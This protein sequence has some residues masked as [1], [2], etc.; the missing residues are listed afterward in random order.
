MSAQVAERLWSAE[1]FLDWERTQPYKHE[2]IDNRVY[3]MTGAS[4]AHN[5]IGVKLAGA[6]DRRLTDR[7]CEVYANDMRV[8]VT[9]ESTYTYPDVVVV[10]GEPR[11]RSGIKPDTLENPTLI[12][13]ILSPTTELIDRNRKLDQYLEMKSVRS[14]FLVSQDKPRI[15]SYSRQDDG[16]LYRDLSGIDA[17]LSIEAIHCELPLREI[18]N[19]V[20]FE[21]VEQE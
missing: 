16:W 1:E 7:G 13:E 17:T 21:S 18:Y 12:F 8:H 6:L 20:R 3:D 11:F 2:L 10:C 19:K 15:E 14:Y 9:R 4:R 5:F